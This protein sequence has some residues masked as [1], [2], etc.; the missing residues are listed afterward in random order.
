MLY[1]TFWLQMTRRVCDR[2]SK[3]SNIFHDI[4]FLKDHIVQGN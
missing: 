3:F 4:C 2:V 1:I